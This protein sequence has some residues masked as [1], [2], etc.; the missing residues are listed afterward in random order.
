M[1]I[2]GEIRQFAV[3]P[4]AGLWMR[5]DGQRLQVSDYKALYAVLGNAYGGNPNI[6]FYVPNYNFDLD[7]GSKPYFYIA[8][9]GTYLDENKLAGPMDRWRIISNARF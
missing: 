1:L 4:N 2:I 7:P 6:D 3:T 9:A 5:C 8:I